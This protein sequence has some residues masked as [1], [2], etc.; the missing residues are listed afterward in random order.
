[1][2]HRL[3]K[4]LGQHILTDTDVLRAIVAAAGVE[5]GDRV[6]EIGPGPGNLTRLLTDAVGSTGSVLAVELDRAWHGPLERLQAERP[7]L[8]V[9]WED[10]LRVHLES[11]LSAPGAPWKAVANIPYYITTPLVERLLSLRRHFSR[12]ALLVQKE[13]AL[14]M[15]A[16][17]GR[18][19]GSV[20]HFV[21]YHCETQI[22]FEVSA[23]AFHPPPQVD[24]AL[25]V[26][27]PRERPPVAVDEERLFAVIHLAFA[28]RRKMLR[29]SLRGLA[30]PEA[31]ENAL[32]RA[33]VCGDRRPED[34]TIEEFAALAEALSR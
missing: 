14:R 1:M 30:S 16:V 28:G 15:D 13:V 17:R 21:H 19:A 26:L 33:E 4:R 6:L 3:K 7:W 10:A 23:A 9:V 8:R 27:I 12:L 34:L 5:P 32:E 11:P 25:L 22:P 2:T 20:S 24:S 29:R 31:L 18:D